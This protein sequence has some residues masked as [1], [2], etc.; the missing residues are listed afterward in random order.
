MDSSN[1]TPSQAELEKLKVGMDLQKLKPQ[2]MDFSNR[3]VR[4][5]L[6]N[7]QM[8]SHS[9]GLFGGETTCKRQHFLPS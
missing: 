9:K 5:D 1:Y 2:K 8:I 3:F 7:N 4:L 6:V